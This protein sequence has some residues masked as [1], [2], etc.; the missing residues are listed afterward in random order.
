MVAKAFPETVLGRAVLRDGFQYS[1]NDAIERTQMD[2]G[3]ARGRL[4]NS[5][6]LA[7]VP[8]KFSWDEFQVAFFEAW[9]QT[10]ANRGASWF[11]IYLPLEGVSYRQVLA[12]V[13]QVP[14]RIP[15]G[16][17]KMAVAIEFEIHDSLIVPDGIVELVIEFGADGIPTIAA[18]LA[19]TSLAPAFEAWA[20]GF[21]A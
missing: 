15:R 16:S 11:T 8:C 3:L 21:A 10:V 5:N 4:Y 17:V 20:E 7:R 13:A 19:E 1:R 14:P 6:P 12:R 9:L 18:A 2:S